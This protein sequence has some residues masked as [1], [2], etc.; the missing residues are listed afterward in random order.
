MTR[1]VFSYHDIRDRS[2]VF[3]FFKFQS[4]LREAFFFSTNVV[5]NHD[6]LEAFTPSPK[7]A[8]K[9]DNS[10]FAL[11]LSSLNPKNKKNFP[12]T[13]TVANALQRN[14]LLILF[15]RKTAVSI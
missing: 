3:F 6:V 12:N 10:C 15:H 7:N 2:E 1:R 8:G 11:F 5:M 9:K 13:F 4:V 14:G